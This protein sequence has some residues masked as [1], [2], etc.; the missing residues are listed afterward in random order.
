LAALLTAVPV[1]FAAEL[2]VPPLFV[3]SS[4]LVAV[5]CAATAIPVTRTIA[6]VREV[7]RVRGVM[8]SSL[9]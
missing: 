4:L 1:L 2:T 7:P 5:P 9:V 6:A 3:V 8:E